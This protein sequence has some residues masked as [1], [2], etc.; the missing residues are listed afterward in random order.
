MQMKAFDYLIEVA[1]SG[2]F[3]KA[4]K[5]LGISQQ[6]LTK[7]IDSLESELGA[8]LVVRSSRGARLTHDGEIAV[9]HAQQIS[10]QFNLLKDDLTNQKAPFADPRDRIRVHVSYYSAMI[11]SADIRYVSLL[12]KNL[13]YTEEPFDKLVRL[14]EVSDGTDLV[15]A[16]VYAH[17]LRELKENEN[18]RFVPLVATKLGFI[19][20]EGSPLAD[21]RLIHRETVSKLPVGLNNSREP[22]LLLDKLFEKHPFGEIRLETSSPRM[23]LNYALS[24][25][26][27]ACSLDS[28]GF[29]L[30]QKYTHQDFSSLRF[31]PLST[32]NAQILI[33]FMLPANARLSPKAAE[34]VDTLKRYLKNNCADY[35]EDNP[36]PVMS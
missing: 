22:A 8:R 7:V 11:A 15:F 18:L 6:G 30:A 16:D 5:N 13:I 12:A 20:K 23:L 25:Q 35:F 10:N 24:S 21:E 27:T 9:S 32:P 36:L 26:D 28:L 19:W 17:T 29:Y 33:G 14:A 3:Y 31:T 1:N 2:S 34:I 4:A